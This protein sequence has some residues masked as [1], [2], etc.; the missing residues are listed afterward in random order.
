MLNPELEDYLKTAD[1]KAVD[2]LTYLLK[3][4]DDKGY[5]YATLDSVATECGTTKV[6]VS[7]VFQ[8]LYKKGFLK[9]I[10]NGF[11]RLE[12]RI[13]ELERRQ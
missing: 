1:S 8:K 5:F 2:V 10:S 9:K 11:Y 6:T 4:A 7:N 12:E 13:A 3:E